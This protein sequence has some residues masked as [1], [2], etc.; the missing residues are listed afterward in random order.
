M[1]K[2]R[3]RLID[4]DPLAKTGAGQGGAAGDEK[5]VPSDG[6]TMSTGVGLKESEVE[7]LDKI[8]GEHGV[9]RNALMRYGLRWFLTEYINGRIDLASDIEVP[10]PQPN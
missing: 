10:Q 3:A 1:A 9:A 5:R 4:S 7:L 2:K 8:A 6:R